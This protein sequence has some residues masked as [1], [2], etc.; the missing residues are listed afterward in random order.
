MESINVEFVQNLLASYKELQESYYALQNRMAAFEGMATA[1]FEAY[2]AELAEKDAVIAS[3]KS[4]VAVL[5]K[6]L[7]RYREKDKTNSRNSHMPP[8]SDKTKFSGV[9]RTER[10]AQAYAIIRSFLSTAK[11]HGVNI[12][13]A[14]RLAFAGRAREAIWGETY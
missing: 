5:T 3:L 10:G 6:K 9:M 7:E 1:K 12:M 8:S 2:E 13:V 11:K 14:L 4:E